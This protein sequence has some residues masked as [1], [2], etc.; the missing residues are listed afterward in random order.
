MTTANIS[1][2]AGAFEM[3][4][5]NLPSLSHVVNVLCDGGYIG[6]SFADH[7]QETIG[8]NVEI[9]KRNELHQFQV[10]P[11]RWIV[12]RS[13]GWLEKCRRLWKNCEHSLHTAEQMI[14]FAFTALILK[15][16]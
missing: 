1:D 10:L 11:K 7:I 4:E 8:A 6:R 3:V 5:N 14:V 2:K 16:F 12:E 13:L 15:R 9:V